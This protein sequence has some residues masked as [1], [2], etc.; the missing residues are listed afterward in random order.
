M[1]SLKEI[2]RENIDVIIRLT[3]KEHQ[4]DQVATNAESISQGNYYDEA[5]FRA[6]YFNEN[7]VGFVM[8][9]IDDKKKEYWLW[10][11]MI[12]KKYQ[13][14]GYGKEAMHQ[15]IDFIKTNPN[16]KELITSYVPKEKDGADAFYLSLGFIDTGKKDGNEIIMKYIF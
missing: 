7:P 12:D 3:V 9:S 5:W 14:K 13:D 16:I 2:T 8:L 6:I 10:R 15:V 4:K 11:L 1:I